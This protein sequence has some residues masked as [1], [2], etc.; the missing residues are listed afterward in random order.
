MC[1]CTNM[2]LNVNIH[3]AHIN[4]FHRIVCILSQWISTSSGTACWPRAPG[5]TPPAHSGR[6]TLSNTG[7]GWERGPK[8]CEPHKGPRLSF[9][10]VRHCPAAKTAE[11]ATQPCSSCKTACWQQTLQQ[12][13]LVLVEKDNAFVIIWYQNQCRLPCFAKNRLGLGTSRNTETSLDTFFLLLWGPGGGADLCWCRN[14]VEINDSWMGETGNRL[15]RGD[16]NNGGTGPLLRACHHWEV[17]STQGAWIPPSARWERTGGRNAHRLRVMRGRLGAALL[18]PRYAATLPEMF[19]QPSAGNLS[20]WWRPRNQA[21]WP[22]I[23]D[24]NPVP[25]H[26]ADALWAGC[27]VPATL[28]CGDRGREPLL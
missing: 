9:S 4:M 26:A 21:A 20:P 13:L 18:R 24:E 3:I 16:P 5:S 11:R 12:L 27:P 17:S 2:N 7:A 6:S 22:N 10:V 25:P 23:K 28:W 1:I 8:N 14:L 19:S 15:F